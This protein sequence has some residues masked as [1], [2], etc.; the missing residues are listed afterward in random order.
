LKQIIYE[1]FG[2]FGRSDFSDAKF[3]LKSV[4]KVRK[5]A[6]IKRVDTD[7]EVCQYAQSIKRSTNMNEQN[8]L[9]SIE[10]FM[11]D[12]ETTGYHDKEALTSEYDAIFKELEPEDDEENFMDRDFWEDAPFAFQ[13]GS[14]AAQAAL[15]R[16]MYTPHAPK[17]LDRQ[18]M[19]HEAGHAV[20]AM[21]FGSKVKSYGISPLPH[22][23][24]K[25]KGLTRH[26]KGV[27]LCAGGEMAKVVYGRA[28][29]GE[30]SDYAMA[31]H[32]GDLATFKREA[33]DLCTMLAPQ[34]KALVVGRLGSDAHTSL[35]RDVEAVIPELEPVDGHY[36]ECMEAILYAKMG[37]LKSWCIVRFARFQIKHPKLVAKFVGV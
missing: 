34:A 4:G 14:M 5:P 7:K 31:E 24:V 36:R 21:H 9:E 3:V 33:F 10:G 35:N 25:Q 2:P 20:V 8:I 6:E 32:F 18:Y 37:K 29:G 28:I 22:C 26:Q 13:T 23:L 19:W 15:P 16:Q 11:A 17:I 1:G 30:A 12:D 27:L